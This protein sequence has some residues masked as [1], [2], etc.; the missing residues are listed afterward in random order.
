MNS[1]VG[2]LK[3]VNMKWIQ[4]C[5]LHKHTYKCQNRKKH[6]YRKLKKSNMN[7]NMLIVVDMGNHT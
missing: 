3:S 4:A 7:M 6:K 1:S 2:V 5:A